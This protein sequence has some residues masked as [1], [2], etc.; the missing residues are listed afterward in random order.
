VAGHRTEC[1]T[2]RRQFALIIFLVGFGISD[3]WELYSG[4]WWQPTS[5]LLLKTTCLTGLIVTAALIY[6]AR[7]RSPVKKTDRSAG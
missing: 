5:L 4:A 1:I 2:P 3:L 7:W 6:A